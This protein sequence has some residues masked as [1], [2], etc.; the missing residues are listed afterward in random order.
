MKE[1]AKIKYRLLMNGEIVG[2]ES[3]FIEQGSFMVRYSP[4]QDTSRLSP[5]QFYTAMAHNEKDRLISAID[6]KEIYANDIWYNIEDEFG[7]VLIDLYHAYHFDEARL[8]KRIF[9]RDARG[10]SKYYKFIVRARTK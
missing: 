4:M 10:V 1:V 9:G 2:Y 3:H 6:G 5:S 7:F 8:S